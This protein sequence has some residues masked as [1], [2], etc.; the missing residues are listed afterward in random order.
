MNIFRSEDDARS[1]DLFDPASADSIRPVAEYFALFNSALFT[2]RLQ[3]D[4]LARLPEYMGETFSAISQM[5]E[6]SFWQLPEIE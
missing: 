1:W 3:P 6:G 4:Y 5:G 2:Q